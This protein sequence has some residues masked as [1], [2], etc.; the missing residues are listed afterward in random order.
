MQ[1]RCVLAKTELSF[2]LATCLGAII[3]RYREKTLLSC[4]PSN[5]NTICADHRPPPH[6]AVEAA[7]SVTVKCILSRDTIPAFVSMASTTAPSATATRKISTEKVAPVK[8]SKIFSSIVPATLPGQ[9]APVL[10]ALLSATAIVVR[11]L[12]SSPV[13]AAT[14]TSWLENLTITAYDKSIQAPSDPTVIVPGTA[15][16]GVGSA[17]VSSST[18]LWVPIL[19][20]FVVPVSAGS[21]SNPLPVLSSSVFQH[22]SFNHTDPLALIPTLKSVATAI[23][24]VNIDPKAPSPYPEY[25]ASTTYNIRLSMQRGVSPATLLPDPPI[26]WNIVSET[27]MYF[28]PSAFPVWD[29][30][31]FGINE[32][33]PTD[34]SM[35]AFL[36]QPLPTSPSSSLVALSSDGTPPVFDD[37]V[38][39]INPIVAT[40]NLGGSTL[41]SLPLTLTADQ[42]KY[43]ASKIV[44]NPAVQHLPTPVPAFPRDQNGPSFLEDLYTEPSTSTDGIRKQ[45]EGNLMAYHATNDSA[46]QKLAPFIFAASAAIYA[47]YQTTQAQTASWTFPLLSSTGPSATVTLS[48]SNAPLA[49]SFVVPAAYFYALCADSPAT[50]DADHRYH[51]V[52][53]TTP[54]SNLKKLQAAQAKGFLKN[55]EAPVT[56]TG[57]TTAINDI[58]A[59]LRI[60]ALSANYVPGSDPV[61]NLTGSVAT[62]VSGCLSNTPSSPTA[63]SPFWTTS[64][65]GGADYLNLISLVVTKAPSVPPPP[66]DTSSFLSRILSTPLVPLA[67][68]SNPP[69]RAIKTASDFP[70][71]TN[72]EW[73]P[74]I[75]NI[76]QT[77]PAALPAWIGPGNAQQ[78]TKAFTTWLQTLFTVGFTPTIYTPPTGGNVGLLGT[79]FSTDVL[80]RFFSEYAFQFPP[81]LSFANALVDNQISTI[82]ST[83]SFSDPILQK[84]IKNALATIRNLYVM[85]ALTNPAIDQ[86]LQFSYMEALYARGFTTQETVALLSSGQFTAALTGTVAYPAAG[87]IYTLATTPPVSLPPVQP[88]PGSG[89]QPCN[90]GKLVNCIPPPNL[91]PFGVT[92]YL[93]DLLQLSLGPNT[94]GDAVATR[95]GPVGT[96][97][98]ASEANMKTEIVVVDIV[99]ESLEALGSNLGTPNGMV[100]NTA[101]S[102]LAVFKFEGPNGIPADKVLAAV[103][104]YSSPSTNLASP[105]VYDELK[106]TYSSPNL[107]YSQGLDVCRSYLCHLGTTRFDTMRHFRQSITEFPLS[108]AQEP[109]DFIKDQWRLPVRLDLALEYLQIS[110]DEYKTLWSTSLTPVLIAQLYGIDISE[111]GTTLV[112][113]T[114]VSGFLKATCLTYCEFLDVWKSGIITISSQGGRSDSLEE[115]VKTEFPECPPC[116]LDNL[117]ISF[118]GKQPVFSL[119]I[120]AVFLRLWR[121]LQLR[122]QKS[123]SMQTLADICSVLKLFTIGE[124][125]DINPDFVRQLGSLLMLVDLFRLPLTDANSSPDA[126]GADRTKILS[127]WANPPANSTAR[128]WAINK[129]LS[130][131]AFHSRKLYEC[132]ERGPEFAKILAENLDQL[133]YLAGFTA[134]NPWFS[135]PTCTIRF[136]EI[137]AKLY[138]S[139][140]TVGE[141]VFLF[142]TNDH[143]D[144]DDPFQLSTHAEALDNPLDLPY[145]SPHHLVTLRRKL[146]DVEICEDDLEKWDW[147][148]VESAIREAGLHSSPGGGSDP[149]LYMAQ[150]FFPEFLE[151]HG[152]HVSPDQRRFA[153]TLSP[154]STS[155]AI[156]NSPP[157]DSFHYASDLNTQNGMINGN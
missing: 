21:N 23:I 1:N 125:L 91:S 112:G 71:V 38:Q 135:S 56:A 46:A 117:K 58:E 98:T 146:L 124:T 88:E 60:S 150:H 57:G 59:T 90:P 7:D 39:A 36:P 16:W 15:E 149:L 81:G 131:I 137:L 77:D 142:T 50:S 63:Q 80:A 52:L 54:E 138:A 141:I 99:N 89:F 110:T 93:H 97:L 132:V 4:K 134:T 62:L 25:P 74:F 73:L 83:P 100:Y 55:S 48:G 67:P 10:P 147:Y 3:L 13:S 31:V 5:Y 133:S 72:A 69:S 87:A 92:S 28:D 24:L 153:T 66:V 106:V 41:K 105:S 119:G 101:D 65:F 29:V 126:S 14:F 148:S 84:W 145:D 103:P 107:P 123:L 11:L 82:L 115:A 17:S 96:V 19:P 47:E 40:Y 2:R 42:C 94:L 53:T 18:P 27:I 22:Y 114:T 85:T 68:G 121:K 152:Y 122:C 129:F 109:A 8:Q 78:Q 144:G 43:I 70:L 12:P 151:K 130:C 157:C 139:N 9:P 37:L 143:L 95:R 34:P 86:G 127:I 35:Y 140:F 61:L 120:L 104:Q 45:F 76:L 75:Q 155:P 26:E 108:L 32:L 64:I 128:T 6:L 156:W 79:G 49:S 111:E 51:A 102:I 113:L 44:Y 20:P 136:A 33:N 118:S 116:C 30:E 154:T